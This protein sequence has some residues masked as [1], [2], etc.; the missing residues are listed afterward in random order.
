MADQC[1]SQGMDNAAPSSSIA[2]LKA[3]PPLLLSLHKLLLDA[4]RDEYEKVFGKVESAGQMLEL[5][6]ED[7]WFSWLRRLSQIIAMIDETLEGKTAPITEKA[8]QDLLAETKRLLTPTEEGEGFGKE[9]FDAL[10]RDPD[11]IFKHKEIS[12]LIS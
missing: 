3:L 11:V 10:Q 4:E 6:I 5:V 8:A 1:Y 12:K 2:R 7:P 9:Y